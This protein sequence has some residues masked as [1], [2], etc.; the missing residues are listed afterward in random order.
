MIV[1]TDARKISH[2]R[3]VG[4]LSGIAIR[5]IMVKQA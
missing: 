5:E 1:I 2:T 4:T 3:H